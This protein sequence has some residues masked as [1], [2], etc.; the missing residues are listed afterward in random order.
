[1]KR[2]IPVLLISVMVSSTNIVSAQT[3]QATPTAATLDDQIAWVLELINGDPAA[4]TAELMA[5]RMHESVLSQ[6]SPDVLAANLSQIVAEL[7]PFELEEGTRVD[8]LPESPTM[9]Q[10]VLVANNGTR[11]LLT[12]AIDPDSGLITGLGFQPAPP[13]VASPV[14]SPVNDSLT[15]TEVTFESDG[16]TLYGSLKVPA[17]LAS[18]APAALIISGSG[19]TDRN[20]NSPTLPQMQTNHNLATTLAENGVI[21]LRYD[22]LGSG[23]T[24]MGNRTGT[25]A[26]TA[27]LFL[28]EARDAAAFLAEQPGVD[29]SQIILVGHSEGALFALALAVELSEA[30]TPPAG[31]VLASPL[32]IRYLDLLHEQIT[33]QFEAAVAS[34]GVSQEEADTA[35]AELDRVVEDLRT[36]G[37]L[38]QPIENP[39]LAS[40][41]SPSSIP[42]VAEIDQW[43]P[44]DF[45]ASLPHD[46]PVLVV[47]GGKDLQVT[48][49]QVDTLM[50]GFADG[51]N[52]G[53]VRVEIPNADH[54]LREV[55]GEPNPNVDY[56]NTDLPFAEDARMALADFVANLRSTS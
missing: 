15:D 26:I 29:P 54:L 52:T 49:Q 18:P 51:G 19:P 22:K 43:D 30:G 31:V 5:E 23:A 44:A 35:V 27:D 45:A 25:D 41:F 39:V 16:D 56:N 2:W 33:G 37:S 11:L 8:D 28:Q 40:L 10:M 36:T 17:G 50:A 34:G 13:A 1:M 38:S 7:G 6:I 24:G 4:I 12:V 20:G 32:S 14:A 46:V 3:P 42:F 47:H 53:V 21:S 48:S 55:E 9:S